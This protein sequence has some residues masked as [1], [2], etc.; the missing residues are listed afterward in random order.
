MK[1]ALFVALL[2]TAPAIAQE[3]DRFQ[4]S[5]GLIVEVGLT[6]IRQTPDAYKNVWVQFDIQFCSMGKV[7]NPFFTQFVPSDYANFYAWAGDQP[8]W[9][10][11]SYD[12]LFGML[13]MH[14]ENPEIHSLYDLRLY[15]RLR[16]TGVVRNVFQDTPWVEVM[17]FEPLTEKV[18]TPT[19]AHLYRAESHITRREWNRAITELSMA[20]AGGKPDFVVAAV[21][22]GLG[23]CYLRVGEA[24]KAQAYLTTARNLDADNRETQRLARA[25][26]EDPRSELDQAVDRSSISEADR[27]M[28][29]A[30]DEGGQTRRRGPARPQR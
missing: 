15:D 18:D 4:N 20:P 29:E 11:E 17:Y 27:P 6:E 10:K 7:S 25:A 8:I 13:F 3:E 16:V 21:N 24:D 12:D 23:L 19:L 28:W 1:R 5:D 30:F 22:Q 9:R 2:A 26:Q 14:K